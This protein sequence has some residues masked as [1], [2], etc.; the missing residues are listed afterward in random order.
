MAPSPTR[1]ELYTLDNR[2]HQGAD[3]V[4]RD[5]DDVTGAEREIVGRDD[6]GSRQEK[7]SGGEEVVSAE[8]FNQVLETAGHPARCWSHLE[9]RQPSRARF[10]S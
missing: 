2:V 1:G 6:S 8:P 9:M 3:A 4:D 7:D 5:A 10:P